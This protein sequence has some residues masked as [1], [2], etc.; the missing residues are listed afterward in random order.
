MAPTDNIATSDPD[1]V[2]PLKGTPQNPGRDPK[3]KKR[4]GEKGSMGDQALMDAIIIVAIAW[5]VI[6]FFA[7]SLR[8]HNV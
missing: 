8:K 3:A 5:A 2:T 1:K 7:L 4:P 6:L